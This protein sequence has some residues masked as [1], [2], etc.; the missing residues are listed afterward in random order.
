MDPP[1]WQTEGYGVD[2][3]FS[4][5]ERMAELMRSCSGKIVVSLNDHPDVRAVFGRYQC[6]PLQ[7]NYTIGGVDSREKRFGELIIKSWD[8]SVATLF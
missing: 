1:Y 4:E 2:F 3:P 7:L 5:Y 6:I 8:D